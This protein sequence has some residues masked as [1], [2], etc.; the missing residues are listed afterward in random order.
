MLELASASHR[1]YDLSDHVE[2]PNCTSITY[3]PAVAIV[4][5]YRAPLRSLCW[6]TPE[7]PVGHEPYE[8]ETPTPYVDE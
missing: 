2:L 3:D 8:L 1:P 4:T 5:V 7:P 6:P